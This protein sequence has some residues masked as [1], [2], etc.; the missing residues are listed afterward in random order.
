VQVF[1]YFVRSEY[2]IEI[3]TLDDL[4]GDVNAAFFYLI[5]LLIPV[6]MMAAW[7]LDI[8]SKLGEGE[9]NGFF[10]VR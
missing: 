1:T 2:S 6:N 9:N 4:L 8:K 5:P 3:L 7:D 10:I